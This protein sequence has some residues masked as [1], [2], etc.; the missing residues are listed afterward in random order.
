[1]SLTEIGYELGCRGYTPRRGCFWHKRQLLRILQR[2]ESAETLPESEAA[3]SVTVPETE[4]IES[5]ALPAA[6]QVHGV[7]LAVT[8]PSSDENTWRGTQP[9]R[10]CG[11]AG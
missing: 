1:M 11:S 6:V 9:G 3:E 5:V 2:G 10:R 7:Q 4:T 8:D